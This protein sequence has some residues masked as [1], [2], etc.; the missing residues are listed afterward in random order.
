MNGMLDL[1]GRLHGGDLGVRG[2][3]SVVWWGC[4]GVVGHGDVNIG[5]RS[6]L[7][8]QI[9]ITFAAHEANYNDD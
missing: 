1:I 5:V 8:F 3:G 7:G 4:R 2:R 6:A 9:A